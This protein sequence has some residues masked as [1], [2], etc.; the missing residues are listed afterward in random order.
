MR[1]EL[2]RQDDVRI[3][4][5]INDKPITTNDWDVFV[6]TDDDS[7]TIIVVKEPNGSNQLRINI[8]KFTKNEDIKEQNDTRNQTSEEPRSGTDA[9]EGI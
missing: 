3:Q 7:Q 1:T 9:Q 4:T 5:W 2:K 6:N 8:S